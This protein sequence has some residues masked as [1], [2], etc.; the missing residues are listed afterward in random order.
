MKKRS[1]KSDFPDYL[2]EILVEAC[3]RVDAKW[4][5]GESTVS[6]VFERLARRFERKKNEISDPK[7]WI[8]FS[9]RREARSIHM[10]LYRET[11]KRNDVLYDEAEMYFENPGKDETGPRMRIHASERERFESDTSESD[12]IAMVPLVKRL[13]DS[14]PAGERKIIGAVARIRGFQPVSELARELGVSRQS[15]YQR[16]RRRLLSLRKT[17]E[18]NYDNQPN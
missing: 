2:S 18:I 7:R 4:M 5:D 1:E 17:L 9:A 3:N 16:V 15:I 6:E 14:L 8:G 11:Q 13:F 12:P 10:R